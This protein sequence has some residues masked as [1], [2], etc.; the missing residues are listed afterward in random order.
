[1]TTSG[2]DKDIEIVRNALDL[3]I[4]Y[5]PQAV[6]Y[7]KTA[8]EAL[9]RIESAL[10]EREWK[11]IETAPRADLTTKMLGVNMRGSE[12]YDVFIFRN[13]FIPDE[14]FKTASPDAC[15]IQPFTDWPCYPTH[16]KPLP[17]PPK[18]ENK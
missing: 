2:N 1:M 7:Y 16:W 10:A 14:T 3:A 8:I 13:S 11:P 15:W 4:V 5:Y 17:Q 9:T 12:P 6:N 18:G